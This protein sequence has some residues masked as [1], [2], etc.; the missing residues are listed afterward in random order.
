VRNLLL[1]LHLVLAVDLRANVKVLAGLREQRRADDNGVRAHDLLV[2]VDVR[3]AFGAVIAIYGVATITLVLVVAWVAAV[4][5]FQVG[6]GD[7]LTSDQTVRVGS[8]AAPRFGICFV[9]G[10]S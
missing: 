5:D 3:R 1:P 9:P 6:F 7:D 10:S 4:G 8:L 2:V